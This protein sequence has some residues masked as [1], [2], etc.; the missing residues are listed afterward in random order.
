MQFEPH[1]KHHYNLLEMLTN[2]EL[3]IDFQDYSVDEYH[4]NGHENCDQE[5][6][7]EEMI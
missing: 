2:P 1:T 4:G 5:H 7:N 6:V 3:G